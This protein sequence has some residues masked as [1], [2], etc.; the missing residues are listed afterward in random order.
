MGSVTSGPLSLG[1]LL[2]LQAGSATGITLPV[3]DCKAQSS[4]VIASP[5]SVSS[6]SLLSPQQGR[7]WHPA[8]LPWPASL[9]GL[10]SCSTARVWQGCAQREGLPHIQTVGL[11]YPNLGVRE[12]YP[13]YRHTLKMNCLYS[14]GT[15]QP[16]SVGRH[17]R[18]SRELS[19]D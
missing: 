17:K 9:R 19:C 15:P 14:S 1:H 18:L 10:G 13:L 11:D 8:S 16:D 12:F 7:E 2:C 4:T 3:C 6:L 5:S